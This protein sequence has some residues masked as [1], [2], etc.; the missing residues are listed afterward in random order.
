MKELVLILLSVSICAAQIPEYK[1]TIAKEN[2]HALTHRDPFSDEYLPAAFEYG[3]TVWKDVKIR[4]KGRSTRYFPKKSYRIKFPAKQLFRNS[5]HLNLHAMYLDKSAMRENLSW[6]LF[7]DMNALAPGASY[8]RLS[9]N[10][11][12]QGLFLA[13]DKI[14]EYFLINHG[15]AVGPLYEAGGFFALAD[16]V[17]HD[18][19][20]LK[21]YYPK[22]IGDKENYNDLHEMLLEINNAP[23]SLFSDVVDRLFDMESV[24]H[25]LAGNI[26]TMMG[27]SYTKN[28]F[29]YRDTTRSIHQWTMIPWDYDMT[30]GLTGDPDVEYPKSLLNEGFSYTFPVLS[31]PE[32]VLKDRIWKTPRLRE[33]LSQYVDTLLHTLFTDERMSH[34]IDSLTA[35]IGSDVRADTAKWGTYED[36]LYHVDA[37]KYFVTARRQYLLA[38]FVN[39][40]KGMFDM[41]TLRVSATDAPYHFVGL[42]GRLL[43][44]VWFSHITKLDSMQVEAYSDSLPSGFDSLHHAQYVKRW[45]RITP[46][47][48]DAKFIA[49]LRWMYHDVSSKDREVPP[50][51]KDERALRCFLQKRNKRVQIAA[52][53]NP[54]ANTVTID[55][56]TQKECGDSTYLILGL[57]LR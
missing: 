42:D 56:F 22:E 47:P 15:Q 54:V 4:Y 52:H 48:R 1:V 55:A 29:L 20:M 53:V 35:V 5:R 39:P 32:N 8:A 37:L 25:W 19:A 27:D 41:A 49:R 17:V 16:M 11:E 12:Q 34:R 33:H 21:Q 9:I 57:P 2:L 14:D 51:V 6:D 26:L 43:A 23:D 45:V 30:F 36:F 38:M 18:T 28:Y 31:G 13:V 7:A 50:D 10:G 24:Y 44:T 3:G 40:P 46:F